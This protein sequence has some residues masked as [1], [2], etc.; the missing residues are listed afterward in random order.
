VDAYAAAARRVESDTL[1]SALGGAIARSAACVPSLTTLGAIAARHG[2]AAVRDDALL[3]VSLLT[4]TR[5]AACTAERHAVSTPVAV[6]SRTGVPLHVAEGIGR[7]DG[8]SLRPATLDAYDADTVAAMVRLAHERHAH[9]ALAILA[10]YA[11]ERDARSTGVDGRRLSDAVADV[12]AETL[13]AMGAAVPHTNSALPASL[14]WLL[15]TA[16][17][18]ERQAWGAAV[19]GRAAFKA[20]STS[21]H[22]VRGVVAARRRLGGAVAEALMDVHRERCTSAAV[23]MPCAVITALVA[24]EDYRVAEPV[25]RPAKRRRAT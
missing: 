11:R 13:R 24:C 17:S 2:L 25:G 7:D 21:P 1:Q 10:H 23:S 3:Q 16:Y 4:G 22:A 12:A 8:R 15:N 5:A 18:A 20:L 6:T 9:T 14:G 19:F